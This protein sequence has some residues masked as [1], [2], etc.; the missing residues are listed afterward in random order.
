[1]RARAKCEEVNLSNGSQEK[2]VIFHLSSA[3]AENDFPILVT[4]QTS[5]SAAEHVYA[6]FSPLSVNA[7][8]RRPPLF[9]FLTPRDVTRKK[10]GIR[11]IL[12]VS[13]EIK[14]VTPV[15]RLFPDKLRCMYI[16]LHICRYIP[17]GI[18]SSLRNEKN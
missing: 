13:D 14:R 1:M 2:N 15:L 16:D 10:L 17:G 3:E 12:A 4:K 9:F 5:F 7:R 8:R 11:G 18:S 6:V